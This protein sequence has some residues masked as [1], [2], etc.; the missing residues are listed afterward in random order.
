MISGLL[1]KGSDMKS[2]ESDEAAAA[3]V[4]VSDLVGSARAGDVHLDD[5]Q[6]GAIIH[7]QRADMLIGDF[8]VIAFIEIACKGSPVQAAETMSI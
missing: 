1:R 2:A 5:D 6:I 3:P 7:P 8:G 4:G